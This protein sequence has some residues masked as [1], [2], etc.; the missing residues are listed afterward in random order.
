MGVFE[1]F[2]RGF[3]S[4]KASNEVRDSDERRGDEVTPPTRLA[5]GTLAPTGFVAEGQQIRWSEA[6]TSCAVT[7]S[8]PQRGWLEG[9]SPP[10]VL[11]PKA[12][13]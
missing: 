7:K 9:L 10:P 13:Q 11:W 1:T 12:S 2:S 6:L 8:R 4:A 5:R 3:A